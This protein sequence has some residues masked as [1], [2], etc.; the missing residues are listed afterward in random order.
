ML[1]F[2]NTANA[3]SGKTDNDLRRSYWLF[4]MVSNPGLVNFGRS[5]TDF[6]I[7][8]HLP[9]SGI[10]KA[11][12]FKQFCGG[13]NI[14][15]CL[16]TIGTLGKYN[17]GSI[18]DYSVEGKVS[19]TDFDNTAA[20]IIKTLQLASKNPH[21]PFGV[22][23]PTGIGRI[24]VM[25]KVSSGAVLNADEQQ[26]WTNMKRRV[27]TICKAAFENNVQILVDAEETWTQVAVDALVRD[28][29][30]KYNKQ[31]PVVYNTAQMYRNDR[32]VY[33]E[34]L[35]KD[36]SEKKYII[37]M[38]LVRGA[39]MEK[40]RERASKMGYS[41]PINETKADTDREYNTA[42]EFCIKNIDR[43]SICAGTHNEDSAALLV[44]LMQ[45]N[46]I[47]PSHPHVWLSQLLGMS[48]HISYN[49]AKEGYNVA[50]YV[51]YGPIK[52][53]LPYLIRRAQENT[54]VKGQTGR[55]LSLII[56]EKERRA[57]SGKSS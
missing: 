28:M 4:K 7:K 54:S 32:L 9:I 23:K 42:L 48:D 20:E 26:A 14:N 11:T 27:D 49:V 25:E 12:I 8:A 13:E 3:F 17:I 55:E 37:G 47:P 2:D 45:Q 33:L 1:S 5:F 29:M 34:N 51:P 21:I 44:K 22:F 16:E 6:A 31:K 53:V 56:K 38:K 24:E 46:N 36:A 43:I 35:L 39:Y 57:P 41:S 52:N 40:E 15:E 18:L 30:E 10:I 50:K 19:E